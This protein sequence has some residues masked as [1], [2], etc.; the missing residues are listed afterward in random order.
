M[1]NDLKNLTN[2][3]NYQVTIFPSLFTPHITCQT[4]N[5]YEESSE[6]ENLG[7]GR[8]IERHKNIQKLTF[9]SANKQ[10]SDIKPK[11]N[12]SEEEDALLIRVVDDHGP[13]SW[14][15]ISAFFPSRV[16]KQCRE[17]WH[18]HLCPEI[19]KT[20]WSEEEDQIIIAAH[21]KYGNK[22]AAIAKCLPGRTD[23]CIKNHWNSTIKR[24]MKLGHICNSFMKAS[25]E[26]L[27]ALPATALPS[28]TKIND[29]R[30]ECRPIG[31]FWC[32]TILFEKVERKLSCPD[33]IFSL[34]DQ[35]TCDFE[36][37]FKIFNSNLIMKNSCDLFN[38]IKMCIDEPVDRKYK[39]LAT[40]EEYFQL[41]CKLDV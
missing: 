7:A 30:V 34:D 9:Q 26:S 8:C 41:I 5:D 1:L 15:K 20:K 2:S 38:E 16:G 29:Q 23:N 39:L 25:F 19:N 14:S 10:R 22:W 35:K 4:D 18:N 24:K 13:K 37:S 28:N 40:E 6:K 33:D 32:D 21:N 12:W 3:R 36:I 11:S 31:E 27:A 17:R